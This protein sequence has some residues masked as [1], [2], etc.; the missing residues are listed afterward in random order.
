MPL[1][2][3]KSET[4]Y[5]LCELC[6]VF[7]V[8]GGYINTAPESVIGLRGIGLHIRN[9][10]LTR[11]DCMHDFFTSGEVYY[12]HLLIYQTGMEFRDLIDL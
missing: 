5:Y 4:Y 7:L 12:K 11:S 10:G 8:G 3:S 6:E 1:Q 9:P 2:R